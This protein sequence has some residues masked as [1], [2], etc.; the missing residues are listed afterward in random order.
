MAERHPSY[1]TILEG[2]IREQTRRVVASADPTRLAD[3]VAE[4]VATAENLLTALRR[5]D[6]PEAPAACAAGCAHC[7]H[8][9]VAVTP[10]EAIVIADHLRATRVAA[11]V[12]ALAATCRQLAAKERGF[13]AAARI[14]ARRPCVLL[15][16]DARC[17]IYEVRPLAC[18]GANA[19]DATQCE[20]A[21]NGA[22]VAVTLYTHQANVMKAAARG[23]NTAT[24]PR[25][26]EL[27]LTAALAVALGKENAAE[28]WLAGEPVFADA[29]LP[30][31]GKQGDPT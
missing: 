11:D 21:L 13:D 14:R 24:E 26:G 31:W 18:R 12:A 10:V 1:E 28:R 4:A 5:Q 19:T 2:G 17:T 22:D 6:P 16:V 20:V 23:L 29:R 3:L 27:E 8:F 30:S 7:C 15:G 25:N 9:Q